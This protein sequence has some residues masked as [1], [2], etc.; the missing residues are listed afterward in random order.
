MARARFK[1]SYA[2]IGKLLRSPRME[3]EMRRRAER[4]RAA[5]SAAAPR[6]TGA[7]AASFRV[8]SGRY[9]GIRHDRAFGRVTNSDEAAPY[10]EFGTSRQEAQHTLRNALKAARG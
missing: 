7:Y 6:D 9:G 5:A 4:V 10:I 1:A 2:G 8:L 3:A